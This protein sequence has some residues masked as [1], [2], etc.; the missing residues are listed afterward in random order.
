MRKAKEAAVKLILPRFGSKMSLSVDQNKRGKTAKA[1]DSPME[2]RTY[3]STSLNG[4]IIYKDEAIIPA[5]GPVSSRASKYIKTAERI[6][7]RIKT[8][9]TESTKPIPPK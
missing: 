6:T 8:I 1:K 7:L 9:F 2:P 3:I 4:A 5:V